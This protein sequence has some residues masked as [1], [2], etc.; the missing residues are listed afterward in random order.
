MP[1]LHKVSILA[2]A[3][4]GVG[5]GG[6]QAEPEAKASEAATRK[7]FP[8]SPGHGRAR[9][10]FVK[11]QGKVFY[12]GVDVLDPAHTPPYGTGVPGAHV[13]LAEYPFTRHFDVTTDANGVWSMWVLKFVGEPLALSFVYEKDFHPP[14]VE[15][16]VFGAPLPAPWA[17]PSRAFAFTR[18]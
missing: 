14:E 13:W 17:C 2:A 16:A 6:P 8:P 11:L 10:E 15:Q 9:V 18:F 12:F 1:S 4:I 5:C 3:L 7:E